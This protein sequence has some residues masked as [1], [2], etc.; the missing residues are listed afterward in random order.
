MNQDVCG[1]FSS[2]THR[3]LVVADGM[4]GHSG[5]E[6]ASRLALETIGT[7]FDAGFDDPAEMLREAFHA[8]N[9]EIHRM[10]TE[11]TALHGMGTT[12]VALLLGPGRRAWVAHVGDSRAYR[13][14]DGELHQITE[15]HSWVSQEVRNH[16][17]TAVEADNHPMK[18]VLLRSIGVS[19][20]VE[21]S[22]SPIEIHA[23]DRFLLCSDGLWGEVPSESIAEILAGEEPGSAVQMLVDLANDC[24][25]SDNITVQVALIGESVPGE[26][27]ETDED[28]TL[29]SDFSEHTEPIATVQATPAIES[30]AVLSNRWLRPV[31]IGV[32]V[33]AL[34]LLFG[35][36]AC[37]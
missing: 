30:R 18:N 2:A 23:G 36:S 31:T 9:L 22:V 13:L 32:G 20:R 10:G 5:G 37:S 35:R 1:E 29:E 26:D 3:L 14:R 28:H 7:T 8:A 24:G 6:T 19:D 34:A 12:G 25:G 11:N 17:I 15:D 33:L 4:G 27:A 16:R 21:V